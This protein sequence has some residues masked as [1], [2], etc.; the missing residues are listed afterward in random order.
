VAKPASPRQKKAGVH[1]QRRSIRRKLLAQPNNRRR[2]NL[3]TGLE[4]SRERFA[5]C[6]QPHGN[7]EGRNFL[8]VSIGRRES[9]P[10]MLASLGCFFGHLSYSLRTARL[11]SSFFML[12]PRRPFPMPSSNKNCRPFLVAPMSVMP[13]K[14]R[15]ATK[16][17]SVAMGHND[18]S[19]P[20]RN[21]HYSTT[22]SAIAIS[23]GGITRPSLLAVLTLMAK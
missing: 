13:R 14:R 1:G 8:L 18:Q 4:A 12:S 6:C 22:S 9:L 16:M 7:R 5:T 19:A 23:V 11:A 17:R 21:D 15:S 20:R 2:T 10:I 3:P